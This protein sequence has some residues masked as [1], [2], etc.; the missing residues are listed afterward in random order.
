M[1]AYRD[2]NA[3]VSAHKAVAVTKSD[4]T[5]IPPTRG[6]YVGVAGDLVVTMA[7]GETPITFKAAPVGYHPLQVIQVLAATG[8][9]DI[10]ALY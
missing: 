2:A 4:A 9:T 8:A 1:A 5:I 3:T 10:V 7:D 6:L